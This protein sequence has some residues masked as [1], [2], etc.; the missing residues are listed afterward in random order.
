MKLK[1]LV[2]MSLRKSPDSESPQY[3]QWFDW[4]VG[5]IF[6]APGHMNVERALQRG[7]CEKV[8]KAGP[9]SP[10]AEVTDGEE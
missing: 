10:E 4:P 6:E 2:D 1:A 9:P 3:E 5:E 7:I 8:S